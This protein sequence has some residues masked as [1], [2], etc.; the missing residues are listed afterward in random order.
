MA[1]HGGDQLAILL[2]RGCNILSDDC[3]EPVVTSDFVD[4]RVVVQP[5]FHF[6]NVVRDLAG[7]RMQG[8]RRVDEVRRKGQEVALV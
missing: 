3:P 1:P 6:Y 4:F 8:G 5:R 7:Q 2:L